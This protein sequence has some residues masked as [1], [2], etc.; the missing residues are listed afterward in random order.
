MADALANFTVKQE[1]EAVEI[2]WED[3]QDP[4]LKKQCSD[5]AL[6]DF[7]PGGQR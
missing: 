2:E 4:G 5:L 7:P 3:L 6:K 1:E